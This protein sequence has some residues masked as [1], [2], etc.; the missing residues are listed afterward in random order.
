LSLVDEKFED[1]GTYAVAKKQWSMHF[2]KEV[3]KMLKKQTVWRLGFCLVL[4]LVVPGVCF[5]D[6]RFPDGRDMTVIAN[7]DVSLTPRQENYPSV[8]LQPDQRRVSGP[9]EYEWAKGLLP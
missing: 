2:K 8:T 3:T 4:L 9:L 1:D 7:I 6:D 5:A